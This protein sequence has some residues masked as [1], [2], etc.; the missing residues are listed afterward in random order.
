MFQAASEAVQRGQSQENDSTGD[1]SDLSDGWHT[2]L[3]VRSPD[4]SSSENAEE[5]DVKL[6]KLEERIREWLRKDN[7]RIGPKVAQL[8]RLTGQVK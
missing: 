4:V 3:N 8:R 2:G 6:S 7:P 1:S 5:H